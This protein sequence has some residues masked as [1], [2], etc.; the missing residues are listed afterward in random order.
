MDLEQDE[1]IID[2]AAGANFTLFVTSKGRLLGLGEK[3]YAHLTCIDKTRY[4]VAKAEK[5]FDIIL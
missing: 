2:V 1:K 5:A 4:T 3:L